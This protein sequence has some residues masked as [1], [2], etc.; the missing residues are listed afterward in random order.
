M[1]E[2]TNAGS[3]PSLLQ[4]VTHERFISPLTV[5][6]TSGTMVIVTTAFVSNPYARLR[7]LYSFVFFLFTQMFN[8]YMDQLCAQTA[9]TRWEASREARS[10]KSSGDFRF[11]REIHGRRFE[12]Y[13]D[14]LEELYEFQNGN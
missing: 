13:E 6:C 14:Y 12:T 4:H 10:T 1:L 5:T 2:R 7:G 9:M 3:F 8:P 11:P